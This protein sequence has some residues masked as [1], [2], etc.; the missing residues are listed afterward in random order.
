MST[1]AQGVPLHPRHV[2]EG[3]HVGGGSYGCL[4][5]IRYPQTNGKRER[6][7]QVVSSSRSGSPS[8]SCLAIFLLYSSFFRRFSASLS[9]AQSSTVPLARFN[10]GFC[11]ASKISSRLCCS[12]NWIPAAVGKGH[13]IYRCSEKGLDLMPLFVDQITHHSRLPSGV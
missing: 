3:G 9:G 5:A 2:H 13:V 1:A 6:A 4:A 8:A 10:F 12:S 7:F 11:L